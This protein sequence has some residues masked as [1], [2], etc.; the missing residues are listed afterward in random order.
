MLTATGNGGAHT[1]PRQ[2][3]H[4]A[5]AWA[6]AR[7]LHDVWAYGDGTLAVRAAE[8]TARGVARPARSRA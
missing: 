2:P 5:A 7:L 1:D 4:P 6:T 3:G 8:D